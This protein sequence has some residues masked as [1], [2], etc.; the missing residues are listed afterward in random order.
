MPTVF[1]GKAFNFKVLIIFS[2]ARLSSTDFAINLQ[3]KLWVLRSTPLNVNDILGF[4][5]CPAVC[6]TPAFALSPKPGNIASPT[7]PAALVA[8]YVPSPTAAPPSFDAIFFSGP[9]NPPI[10]LPSGVSSYCKAILSSIPDIGKGR[11][12][13]SGLTFCGSD[14]GLNLSY[15]YKLIIVC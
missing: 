14:L 4:N 11:N 2:I 1:L 3:V 12:I 10:A 13:L 7:I 6:P 8:A 15:L 9:I 5:A